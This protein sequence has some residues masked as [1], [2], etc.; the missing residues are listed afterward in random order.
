MLEH[1][2]EQIFRPMYVMQ[3]LTWIG[4]NTTK[5]RQVAEGA[6]ERTV[7]VDELPK[8]M[9]YTIALGVTDGLRQGS[10]V[11]LLRAKLAAMSGKRAKLAVKLVDCV[12][13]WEIELFGDCGLIIF[14]CGW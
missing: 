7:D 10:K 13:R 5:K 4:T 14:L 11:P 12:W 2:S 8:H 3:P 9:L 6:E 1:L